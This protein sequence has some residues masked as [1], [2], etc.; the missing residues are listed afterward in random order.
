MYIE[1]HTIKEKTYLSTT[2]EGKKIFGLSPFPVLYNCSIRVTGVVEVVSFFYKSPHVTFKCGLTVI[3]SI[4]AGLGIAEVALQDRRRMISAHYT[5]LKGHIITYN[6]R[7][8]LVT[9]CI[10]R[11]GSVRISCIVFTLLG[12]LI[13]EILHDF[14]SGNI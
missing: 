4:F 7:H 1:K 8:Y 11:K 5:S 9:P 10:E 3:T 13:R 6:N 2:F 12:Y 14:K